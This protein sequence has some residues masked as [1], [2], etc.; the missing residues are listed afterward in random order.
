DGQLVGNIEGH[1]RNRAGRTRRWGVVATP[2]V[3]R[4]QG[5]EWSTAGRLPAGAGLLAGAR[6]DGRVLLRWV[7]H[8]RRPAL[9]RGSDHGGHPAEG[10][11]KPGAPV[12]EPVDVLLVLVD[13]DGIPDAVL[14]DPARPP[15]RQL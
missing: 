11:A 5:R 10:G 6:R 15:L 7:S 4:D 3:E 1:G 8:R 13:V 9:E 12:E 14:G 2:A